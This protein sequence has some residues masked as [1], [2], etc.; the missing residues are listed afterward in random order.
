MISLN[1]N[2]MKLVREVLEDSASLGVEIHKLRSGTTLI[3]MGIH[4]RGSWRAGVLYARI[5]LGGMAE[6]HI[7]EYAIGDKTVASAE[8]LLEQPLT[9]CLA[10]QIAGWQLGAGEFAA[11]GSGPARALAVVDSDTYFKWTPYR[12]KSDVAVLCI[13][14]EK[15]PDDN[16]ALMIAQKCGV[17]P[18]SLYL[19]ADTDVSI[20]GSFQVSA[21]MIEQTI[22]K[23]FKAEFDA[24]KVVSCRGKAPVAPIT[25]N[26]E[27]T[28]GRI[29]D[30]ILYGSFVEFWVDAPDE[31]IMEVVPR[32]VS[33]TSSPQYG[34]LFEDIFLQAGRN[35][36]DIHPHVHC[37][38]KAQ[39]HSVQTG[40]VF[41]AGEIRYDILEKSFFNQE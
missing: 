23:L 13:F 16:M 1:K 29:N 37:I 8:V 26:K 18:Q 22:H 41:T 3:N 2:A 34:E 12:D 24:S 38:A 21:R 25:K 28:M 33:A 36:Y 11:I 27:K 19:I 14:T 7:G 5:A 35:F 6:V 32:L 10:S 4:C 39:F 30:A 15:L 31:E 20:V 40:N 17:E 9:A